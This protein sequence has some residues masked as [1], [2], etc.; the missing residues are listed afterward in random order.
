MLKCN[1][2]WRMKGAQW[3]AQGHDPRD[4]RCR[5]ANR[6][7]RTVFQM[8]SGRQLYCHPSRLDRGYV[9]DKLL[10]YHRQHQ[11]PPHRIVHDL[12]Q[13]AQQIPKSAHAEEAR[14]LQQAAEKSR[15]SRRRQPQ[16]IGTLL[17]AV[18]ARLGVEPTPDERV[19]ST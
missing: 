18:L 1:A 12:E 9:L 4:I 15:R 7:T 14:P 3:K 11:T 17:V 5:V 8:I 13:A 16:A 6:L 10:T 19:P 2:Y